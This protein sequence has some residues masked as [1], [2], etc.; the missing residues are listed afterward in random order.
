MTTPHL[1]SITKLAGKRI[2]VLGGTSGIGFAVAAAALE[3]GALVV[4]SSSQL[5]NV[6]N[7]VSRLKTA[8]PTDDFHSRISGFTCDLGNPEKLEENILVL[9]KQSTTTADG[10]QALLDHIVFTAGDSQMKFKPLKEATVDYIRDWG[11]VRFVAP[12]ILAKLVGP[13]IRPSHT[14]TI[15]LTSGSGTKKPPPGWSLVAGYAGGIETMTRGLAVDLA[16]IRVNCI[17]PGAVHTEFWDSAVGKEALDGALKQ[18]AEQTLVGHVGK[19][20]DIAEAY[21][22]VMKDNFCTGSSISNNG[23]SL[24]K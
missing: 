22:Y 15:T 3:H 20:E 18:Y 1:K 24:L 2:L 21:I 7:A 16:P 17:L 12:L 4:V 5:T 9:L 13:F 11:T 6:E 10:G 23:G 14:S 8:Y 19:P